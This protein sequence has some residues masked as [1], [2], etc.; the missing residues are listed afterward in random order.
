MNLEQIID[1]FVGKDTK[2]TF[3]MNAIREAEERGYN[4]A[5]AEIKSRK[6]ELI[7]EIEKYVDWKIINM[8]SDRIERYTEIT[9]QAGK[10]I[11]KKRRDICDKFVRDNL[12]E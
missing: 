8:I 7:E 2:G 5:K 4:Y 6:Q 1:Q 3:D 10:K 9:E 11:N 12:I